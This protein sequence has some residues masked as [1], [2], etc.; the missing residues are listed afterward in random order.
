MSG[1]SADSGAPTIALMLE[2]T[3]PGGA[4]RM[5]LELAEELRSR[6]YGICPVGPRAERNWLRD[7]FLEQG[8]SP[9]SY[10]LRHP[11][12]PACVTD[13]AGILKRRR[14][15]VVHSHEFTMAVYGTAATRVCRVP[16]VITMHGGQRSATSA[17]RRRVALRWAIR[18]SEATACVSAAARADLQR[19]LGPG[20][21]RLDMVHNGIRFTP[22]S[23]QGIRA[24]LGIGA[25]TPLIL[26]V[27]N[28]YPVK[29]HVHLLRGL[30]E[31]RASAPDLP[32]TLAIAGKVT[33]SGNVETEGREFRDIAAA[34]GFADRLHLLGFREDVPDLLAAADIYVMPSLSEGLPLALLEAM[35][36]GKP[37]VASE[38]GG[39]PEVITS[40]QDGLLVPAGDAGAIA[41]AL[42]DLLRDGGR[43]DQ[44]GRAAHARAESA[45]GV[46]SMTER[47]EALYARS[48]ARRARRSARSAPAL[49]GESW[50]P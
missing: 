13:L 27:G 30:A 23:A 38:V 48:M 41:V 33:L 32:W 1:P 35:F 20:T 10:R 43:R 6:G 26:A 21:G 34:N 37:I 25:D 18:R 46:G 4:E 50:A 36:A 9:E 42:R 39:I 24:A 15:D 19:A 3:A 8:F 14:V 45:F 28:L 31:L 47:Y 2:S 49:T 40:G 17:R 22:G 29:G 44:L 11:L 12:D 7:R 16:H 5:L